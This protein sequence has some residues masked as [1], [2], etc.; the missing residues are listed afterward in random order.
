LTSNPAVAGSIPD[1]SAVTQ[2]RLAK[3]F[4]HARLSSPSSLNIPTGQG[5]DAL[6]L[7]R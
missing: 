7:G 2:R 4:T 5:G 1:R 3:S 6:T